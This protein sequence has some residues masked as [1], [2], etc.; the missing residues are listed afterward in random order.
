MS[1]NS[2]PTKYTAFRCP[3]DILAKAKIA[4]EGQRRSLSN[5]IVN[6]LEEKTQ[7]I[8]VPAAPIRKG[9]SKARA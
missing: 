7:G 2:S 9:R 6:L 5:F 8:E 1:K 4:A 3:V